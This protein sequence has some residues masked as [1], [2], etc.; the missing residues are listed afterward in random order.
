MCP[1]CMWLST[2]TTA[3]SEINNDVWVSTTVKYFWTNRTNITFS[4]RTTAWK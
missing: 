4:D 1:L 3:I 2:G